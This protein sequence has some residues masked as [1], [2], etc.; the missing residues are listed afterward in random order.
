MKK[1]QMNQNDQ[2]DQLN[3]NSAIHPNGKKK[4]ATHIHPRKSRPVSA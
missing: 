2:N 1:K 3:A 4:V